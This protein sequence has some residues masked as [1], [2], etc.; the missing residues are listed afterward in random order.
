MSVK[1]WFKYSV[2]LT[3]VFVVTLV[4][5]VSYQFDRFLNQRLLVSQDQI[6][7]IHSGDSA[8]A[9]LRRLPLTESP[10]FDFTAK[11]YFRLFPES[12]SFKAGIYELSPE[13]TLST[14]LSRFQLG[15]TK[16][17][18]IPLIEGKTWREWYKTLKENPWVQLDVNEGE[19]LSSVN[20]MSGWQLSNL[21]G[22][23]MPDTYHLEAGGK[24]S[25]LM[26]QSHQA[27]QNYLESQWE[28]RALDLPIHSPYQALILASIIEKE[29]G[30]ARE[31]AHIAAVFINRLNLGMRL[32]TDPTVIYGIG[33]EFDGNLTRKH[34]R[35]KTP[36]NTYRINGLP[37]TPIAMPSKAAIKA[38][39]NP[40][41]S[42]DLYFVAKGDGSHKFSKTLKEHNAAV[43]R[44]QLGIQ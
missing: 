18:L 40:I 8:T 35:E 23:F 22:A 41:D 21:E 37:P 6:F 42:D 25:S 30:V 34:L 14:V 16:D 43:R 4:A 27:L 36:Y 9:V 20:A 12:T 29:T 38:A 5:A 3:L 32:Q 19:L 11:V 10:L 33:S 15:E 2:L 26:L 24:L 17:I 44:Y 31:R 28:T 39:L 13:D 1:T 7:N